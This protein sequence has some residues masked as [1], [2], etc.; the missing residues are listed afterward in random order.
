MTLELWT[1]SGTVSAP[2]GQLL[3]A[4]TTN[5]TTIGAS[6]DGVNDCNPA[7]FTQFTFPS[8]H[9]DA[10][11]RYYVHYFRTGPSMNGDFY[12]AN[13]CVNE[14]FPA[15]FLITDGPGDSVYTQNFPLGDLFFQAF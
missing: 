1:Y 5:A 3:R 6:N 9:L 4:A 2:L 7:H 11:T 8:I 14:T 13:I 15:G 12:R 10:G